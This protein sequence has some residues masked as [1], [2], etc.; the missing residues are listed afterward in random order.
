M[1]AALYIDLDNMLG[2]CYSLGYRYK[3]RAVVQ[4]VKD[5][6]DELVSAKSFGSIT[7]ALAH[8]DHFMSEETAIALLDS[9]GIKYQSCTGKKNTADLALS[10]DALADHSQYDTLYIVSSDA[11]FLPLTEKLVAMGKS[12]VCIRMFKPSSPTKTKGFREV[13][14]HDLLGISVEDGLDVK[15]L[16][17]RNVLESVLK[18]PLTRPF[19]LE[20]LM[21]E[22][23][24]KFVPGQTLASLA[25]SLSMK[26]AFKI[27][28]TALYGKA[29]ISDPSDK[30]VLLALS[31]NLQDLQSAYYRQC[32]FILRRY[33]KG[34]ISEDAL[35][36][37]F[38]LNKDIRFSLETRKLEEIG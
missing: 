17:Y 3:P 12:V 5:N 28:R 23:I 38:M 11:D 2:Y 22:V 33:L 32:Q 36:K 15:A 7:S 18:M 8:L 16:V 35:N 6:G 1:R 30:T 14:Y 20:K 37:M 26:D 13:Y 19:F 29:F 25:S 31:G 34:P 21:R 24:E 9:A 10:L 27:L 4:F